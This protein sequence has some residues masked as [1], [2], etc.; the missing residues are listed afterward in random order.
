[1][2]IFLG[3]KMKILVFCTLA[4]LMIVSP[5]FCE[6]L[7]YSFEGRISD[8]YY[9]GAG[10]IAS[11]G[12]KI[13]DPVTAKFYVNFKKDGYF[14]LNNGQKDIPKDPPMTNDVHEYFYASLI[15]GTLLPVTDGGL[16]FNNR[17]EGIREYHL[18][19]NESNPMGNAGMLWGGT[20]NSYLTIQKDSWT[21]VNVETWHVGDHLKGIIVAFS[22]KDWSIIWADVILTGI[23][24]RPDPSVPP[25]DVP[26][27]TEWGMIIFMV[28]A[29]LGSVYYLRRQRSA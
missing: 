1:M 28:L 21:D 18:G 14:I 6:T 4:A 25:A 24:S 7:T 19:Y 27:M 2:R 9:D 13:G 20:G 23:E 29:A 17:P 12:Y 8:F 11:G 15:S 3:G 22:N 16:P 26:T 5:G 10:I